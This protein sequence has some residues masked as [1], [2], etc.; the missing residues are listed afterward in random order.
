MYSS[1][2]EMR[3][4]LSVSVGFVLF[5]QADAQAWQVELSL[6]KDDPC[7]NSFAVS[8][9]A[10]S[11]DGKYVAAGYGIFMGML[12]DS[13]P[14]QTILWERGAGSEPRRSPRATTEFAPSCFRR[15]EKCSRSWSIPGSFV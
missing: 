11:P 10:Y 2:T 3:M 8:S 14:G 5:S 15:M 9:V 12:Q 7:V 1:R 6:P 4:L 13:K